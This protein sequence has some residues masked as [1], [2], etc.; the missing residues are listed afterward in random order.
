MSRGKKITL[1]IF[2]AWPLFYMVLFMC[3]MFGM[4][5]FADGGHSSGPDIFFMIIFPLHFFTMFEILALMVI[6]IV[7]L[8]KTDAVPQDKKALW[9][10]VLLL[11]NMI[12]MPIYWYLYIWEKPPTAQQ[13]DI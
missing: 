9:A 10:V 4:F 13:G 5:F 11:G 6:Y 7:H 3:S 12:A 2:T 8:F 1:A